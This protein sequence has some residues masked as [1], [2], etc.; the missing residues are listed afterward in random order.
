MRTIRGPASIHQVDVPIENRSYRGR[1]HFSFD[2]YLNPKWTRFGTLR[3]FNDDTLTPR[4]ALGAARI[5]DESEVSVR[6]REDAGLVL[7]DVLVER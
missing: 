5:V 7:M 3:V 2:R 4:A 1:R 6:A